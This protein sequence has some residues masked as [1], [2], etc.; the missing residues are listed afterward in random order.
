MEHMVHS[1]SEKHKS[2][3]FDIFRKK[4]EGRLEQTDLDFISCAF[5]RYIHEMVKLMKD[6]KSAHEKFFSDIIINSIDAIIG[7]DN[8]SKVFLWNKGA[9]TLFGWKKE[10]IQGRDFGILIPRKLLINGEKQYMLNEIKTKG[11]FANYETERITK[12]GDLKNV[13]ISRFVIYDDKGTS[14]GNVGIVRD[15]TKEKQLEKELREKENLALIGQ[16]VSSIAHN[17]SNPLNIISGNAD[18]LLLDK[19][20]GDEGYEELKTIVDEAVRITKSIRQILNFAKPL[21]PMREACNLN[22]IL[23]EVARKSKYLAGNKTI[24]IKTNLSKGVKETKIDKELFNDVF[25]NLVNN[26]IQAIPPDIKGIVKITSQIKDNFILTEI[27]DNGSGISEEVIGNIFKPF[28]STKGYGKGTGLGLAFAERVVK[29]H[30]GKIE[31]VSKKEK[32]TT[33]RIFLPQ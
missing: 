17:L 9:E 1:E 19:K 26:A 22:D 12:S 20:D 29:E 30:G 28:F 14:I 13:S 21:A 32:G 2:E 11:Y 16:V 7:F 3:L 4:F 27:T 10:E 15:I 5:N 8:D 18:Y 23:D 25:F 31:V 24:D 33:L 6:G